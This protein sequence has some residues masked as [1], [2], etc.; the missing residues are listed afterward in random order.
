MITDLSRRDFLRTTAALGVAVTALGEAVALEPEWERTSDRVIRIGVVGGG[1]GLSWH[2]HEHPNCRV[3]AVSDLIPD[4]RRQLAAKYSCKKTYEALELLVLDSKV[5]AIALFTPAPDHARHVKLCMEHGKHVI[6]ACP[7]CMTLEEAAE[8]K[9][10]QK[11]T[12][13]TYMTA[14]TSWFRWETIA[15]REL[16]QQD[17]FGEMVY[18]EAEYYHPGIGRAN[19]SHST[20][21]GKRTWR[22]GFPPML[23]P[24][25]CTAFLIGVTGDH[26]SSVSCIGGADASEPA[27]K[28][29]AYSNPFMNGMALFKT[30]LG[31][32][33][34]CNVAWDILAHGERAQWFGDNA[35]LYMEG[36][37]GQPF[38]L[39]EDGNTTTPSPDYWRRIPEKMRYDSGHGK[40]HPFI[41][42]E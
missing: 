30:K 16:H 40:S 14:E 5:D 23:Y 25:H 37:G 8:M 22:Y 2:W 17:A 24:T 7:A 11:K 4:R 3:E 35:A 19:D 26:L 34:R 28:D 13:L 33:F 18:C 6:S 42:N 32:P 27:M 9:A 15:A 39:R 10:I 1:F 29:N 21:N 31:M 20:L 38:A 36:P 41:T 12:G